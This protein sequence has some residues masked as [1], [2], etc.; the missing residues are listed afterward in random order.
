MKKKNR[1]ISLILVFALLMS[2][3][4]TLLT[5]CSCRHKVDGGEDTEKKPIGT[6]AEMDAMYPTNVLHKVSV[7]ETSNVFVDFSGDEPATEYGIVY[8][9]DDASARMAT[10]ASLHI[11]R[12]T[13]VVI[14]PKPVTEDDHYSSADKLIYVNC[15]VQFAEAGLTMPEDNIGQTGYYIRTVGTSVFIMTKGEYGTQHAGISLLQH[16]I[17]YNMYGPDAVV[18]KKTGATLPDMNIIEKP[19]FDF[20]IAA[21]SIDDDT[22]YGMGFQ[23]Y[24]E[25][26]INIESSHSSFNPWHNSLDYLPNDIYL[27]DH[28]DWYSTES[29]APIGDISRRDICYTAHGNQAEYELL[30]EEAYKQMMYWI[31]KNPTIPTI[32]FTI[33]DHNTVC[34]C[35]ACKASA[36]KYNGS[37]AGAVIQF[38][39][40]VNNKIQQKL[41]DDAAASGKE[42][43]E[44][45]VLFF[46]YHKMLTPPAKQNPDGTWSPIDETVVCGDNLGVFIAPI[47]SNYGYSYYDDENERDK[48]NCEGWAACTDIIYA[49]TYSANFL[50]YLFPCNTYDNMIENY[51][52]FKSLGAV[53]MWPQGQHNAGEFSHFTNF[54]D[55]VNSKALFDTSV[56][57]KDLTDD[58]FANYFMDAAGPMR[59][60]YD[61][62]LAHLCYLQEEYYLDFARVTHAEISKSV[63][64]PVGLIAQWGSYI[65]DA[66][67]AIEKY[68]TTDEELYIKLYDRIT[69]ESMFIRYVQASLHAGS[70]TDTALLEMRLAF[71]ADCDKYG[72]NCSAESG[73]ISD[74]FSKWG[75]L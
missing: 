38:L 68:K 63:Y 55:Y 17:G 69:I 65:E 41:A 5:S 40:R 21:N 59:E 50:Y 11:G 61:Q 30:V 3:S 26:F 45:N 53:Y 37:N 51:R 25:I 27:E 10:F 70:Y 47:E 58:Y 60:Y 43:R 20:Y 16:L 18:Y 9:S 8:G 14:E 19:D 32:T 28:P 6:V 71:K 4:S 42:K 64:W 67:R 31:E 56:N 1:Y 74:I 57:M 36:A 46:A 29:F 7:T 13:G 35:D 24:N 44:L 23:D 39:N 15:P 52:F 72:F 62:L 33:E 75:I 66:Y 48:A 54:K 73:Q 34:Q 2:L 22:M 49:W 12:A